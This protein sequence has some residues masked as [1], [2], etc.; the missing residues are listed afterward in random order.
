MRGKKISRVAFFPSSHLRGHIHNNKNVT[1]TLLE[2]LQK[3]RQQA[4]WEIVWKIIPWCV[5]VTHMWSERTRGCT[6]FIT[7]SYL[8]H[9]GADL[10][11][12]ECKKPVLQPRLWWWLQPRKLSQLS[13]GRIPLCAFSWKWMSCRANITFSNFSLNNSQAGLSKRRTWSK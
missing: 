11:M 9:Y 6:G 4:K 12:A 3:G 8:S 2:I 7:A 13:R 10:R 1:R 5:Q